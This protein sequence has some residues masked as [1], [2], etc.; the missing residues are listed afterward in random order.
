MLI[1]WQFSNFREQGGRSERPGGYRG[2][3]SGW[4]SA[5]KK[6]KEK[7]TNVQAYTVH[8][9][10]FS[11]FFSLFFLTAIKKTDWFLEPD[12]FS[13]TRIVRMQFESSTEYAG[14]KEH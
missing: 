2:S 12:A 10:D 3:R 13:A 1:L 5:C 9:T 14:D 8:D 11:L 7:K 4:F 6:K